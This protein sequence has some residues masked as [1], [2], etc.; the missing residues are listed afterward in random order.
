MDGRTIM[1]RP[2]RIFQASQDHITWTFILCNNSFS[3]LMLQLLFL[4]LRLRIGTCPLPSAIDNLSALT[5]P[6]YRTSPRLVMP[7][8]QPPR[9]NLSRLPP[10]TC[11]CQIRLHTHPMIRPF[12]HTNP[13][14]RPH[15]TS[16]LLQP[17]HR[18]L[19]I[20]IPHNKQHIHSP[21]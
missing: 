18:T 5:M 2:L 19:R 6:R 16:H 17:C 10:H 11:R 20:C 4:T 9:S 15:H 21:V 13:T 12:N 14:P 8:F 7:L 3:I 1:N